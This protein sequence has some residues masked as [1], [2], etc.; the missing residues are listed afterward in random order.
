MPGQ[1]KIEA[2]SKKTGQCFLRTARKVFRSIARQQ[3][4][5][6]M[7]YHDVLDAIGK[8]A[9]LSFHPQ[10]LPLIDTPAFDD[11]PP[12]R[13]DAGN[14]HFIVEIE[15]LQVVRNILLIDVETASKPCVDVVQR[16]VMI[17]RDDDLRCRKCPQERTGS[18]ELTWPGTLRKVAR[19]G[20]YVRL[21]L[22]NGMNKLLDDSVIGSTEVYI[23]E[24][25]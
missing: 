24:M 1:Q 3:I 6:M 18:V 2:A 14:C 19:D 8:P 4:E 16:H 15:G 9:E 5:R 21:D 12:G 22:A 10:H 25:D 7:R 11:E 20:Y 13:I 23:G 17:S